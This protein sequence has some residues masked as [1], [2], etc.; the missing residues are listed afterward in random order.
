MSLTTVFVSLS[1]H[2]KVPQIG[3]D[4]F[5]APELLQMPGGM[6]SNPAG[7]LFFYITLSLWKDG[8]QSYR[9]SCMPCQLG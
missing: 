4:W 2:N 8:A 9:I 3:H 1:C 5:I 6:D 7:T